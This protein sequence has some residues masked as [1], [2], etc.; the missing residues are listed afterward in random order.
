MPLKTSALSPG[1]TR[2]VP[3]KGIDSW[4]SSSLTTSA[5]VVTEVGTPFTVSATVLVAADAGL[6]VVMSPAVSAPAARPT[7]PSMRD[8]RRRAVRETD[9]QLQTFVWTGQ[10]RSTAQR[11]VVALVSTGSTPAVHAGG[12]SRRAAKFE[13]APA[14]PT[15]SQ[16]LDGAPAAPAKVK[17][18]RE[19][20]LV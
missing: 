18:E 16:R 11:D 12:E 15:W 10:E 7:V 4:V 6:A 14:S 13:T 8:V 2:S 20:T 1:L 3:S 17:G 19:R 5:D 9:M